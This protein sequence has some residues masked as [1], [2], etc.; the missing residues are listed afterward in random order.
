MHD[1]PLTPLRCWV[2]SERRGNE[3]GLHWNINGVRTER[4]RAELGSKVWCNTFTA[5]TSA[6]PRQPSATTNIV[7]PLSRKDT[8][9]LCHF[10]SQPPRYSSFVMSSSSNGDRS[11]HRK[12]VAS[13]I[14]SNA[15]SLLRLYHEIGIGINDCGAPHGTDSMSGAVL[16]G[17]VEVIGLL[18]ELAV[19]DVNAT[20]AI[21]CT[22]LQLA[23]FVGTVKTIRALCE[24]GSNIHTP[25]E[26]VSTPVLIAAC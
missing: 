4:E 16:L 6:T 3:G 14:Q 5:T 26:E 23:S 15:I 12:L 20:D 24:L 2:S 22:P 11:K 8:I 7:H 10:P 25:N 9:L 13:A 17:H 18:H 21:C 1:G 19:A